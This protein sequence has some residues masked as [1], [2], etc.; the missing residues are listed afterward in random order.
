MF[1]LLARDLFQFRLVFFGFVRGAFAAI[2][3][4]LRL[5]FLTFC[6]IHACRAFKRLVVRHLNLS[7]SLS[8]LLLVRFSFHCVCLFLHCVVVCAR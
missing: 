7:M 1:V 8:F 2:F 4:D 5:L 3:C 6:Y